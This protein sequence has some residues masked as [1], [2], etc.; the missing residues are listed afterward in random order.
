MRRIRSTASSTLQQHLER[1]L[2]PARGTLVVR[3]ERN[4]EELHE[5]ERTALLGEHAFLGSAV[6]DE[7]PDPEVEAWLA[8]SDAPVVYVSLGSFLSVRSDILRRVAEALRGLTVGG[9]PVRVLEVIEPA[10]PPPREAGD[11]EVTGLYAGLLRRHAGASTVKHGTM[12]AR[13]SS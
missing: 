5:P 1:V 12:A 4:P 8:R 7:P 2:Q 11:S 9:T 13:P 3:V 6:R 10:G